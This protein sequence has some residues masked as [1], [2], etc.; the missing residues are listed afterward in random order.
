MNKEQF[1]KV[2][3]SLFPLTIDLD[4]EYEEGDRKT[5]Y[6]YGSFEEKNYEVL[7]GEF[8]VYADIYINQKILVDSGN[9][10]EPPSSKLINSTID[11]DHVIVKKEKELTLTPEQ[12]H[13]LL[14]KIISLIRVE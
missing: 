7:V 3:G 13:A 10:W 6:E 1:D 4:W 12:E 2:I 8:D 5:N 14:D 9:Y 11:V